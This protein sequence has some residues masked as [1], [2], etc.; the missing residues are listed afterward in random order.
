MEKKDVVLVV[1]NEEF[2]ERAIQNL[3]FDKVNLVMIIKD[4]ADEKVFKVGDAEI[5]VELFSRIS[6]YARG[7][8]DFIWLIS[9]YVNGIADL[10]AVKNFLTTY[11]VPEEKIFNFEID[12]QISETWFANL[13]YIEERGADFFATGNADMQVG[14][15][16]NYIPCVYEDKTAALGG[17]NLSDANQDLRQ[18]YLTARHVFQKAPSGTIKFVLIGLSPHSFHY[19]SFKKFSASSK[20]LQYMSLSAMNFVS[21]ELQQDAQKPQYISTF[22]YPY[23]NAYTRTMENFVGNSVKNVFD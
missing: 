13:H 7:D 14:L 18:S 16:F 11:G 17:V 10:D 4:N 6:G 12:S 22:N 9:G 3:N 23:P 20:N 2:L 5:P 15:N 1:L 19:D 21:L 8:N